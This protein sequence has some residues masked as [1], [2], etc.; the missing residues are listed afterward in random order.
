M[1]PPSCSDC[2]HLKAYTSPCT[3]TYGECRRFP[4][5]GSVWPMVRTLDWCGEFSEATR[6]VHG[7]AT[8]PR[9]ARPVESAPPCCARV[10][11]PPDLL[12]LTWPRSGRIVARR[13]K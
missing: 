6:T 7:S 9:F 11:K 8:E 5:N 12:T 1:R 13:R 2:A 3:R 4:P 10:A